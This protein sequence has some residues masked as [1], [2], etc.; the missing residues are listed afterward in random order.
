MT[1]DA[2]I[3]SV[4]SLYAGRKKKKVIAPG[5]YRGTSPSVY[6]GVEDLFARYIRK[7]LD[8]GDFEIW[9]DPQISCLRTKALPRLFRTGI[10]VVRQETVIMVF[11][12]KT[13]LSYPKGL[14]LPYAEK[15]AAVSRELKSGRCSINGRNRDITFAAGLEWNFVVINGTYMSALKTREV[16][17]RFAAKDPPGSLFVLSRTVHPNNDGVSTVNYRTFEGPAKKLTA[18]KG[19]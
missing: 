13:D 15:Q 1:P 19:R 16:E 6:A 10:C 14:F 17:E 8:G 4:H 11:E 9:A 12:L 5:I 18:L 2:F 7:A 3:E